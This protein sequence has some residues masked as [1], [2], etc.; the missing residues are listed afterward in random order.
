MLWIQTGVDLLLHLFLMEDG[1]INTV[2]NGKVES[3]SKLSVPGHSSLSSIQDVVNNPFLGQN[4]PLPAE[5]SV[6][7]QLLPTDKIVSTSTADII[8]TDNP[9]IVKEGENFSNGQHYG[10]KTELHLQEKTEP[11]QNFS[12]IQQSQGKDTYF[13]DSSGIRIDNMIPIASSHEIGSQSNELDL[14]HVKVRMQ[15]DEPSSPYKRMA[16]QILRTPLSLNSPGVKLDGTSGGIIDTRAPFESVKE[17]VSK[18]G[19]IVDWKAHK[20]QTVEVHTSCYFEND[21]S[22]YFY[23]Y[24]YLCCIYSQLYLLGTV[25]PTHQAIFDAFDLLPCLLFFFLQSQNS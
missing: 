2:T 16:S 23:H 5:N 9:D 14:P 7:V 11:L 15:T 19:G 10:G 17:A 21:L 22:C 1:S 25:S 18:F 13:L 12:D 24:H 4:Q 3:G 20:I 8:E 6:Q